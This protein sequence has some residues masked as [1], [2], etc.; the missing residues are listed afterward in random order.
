MIQSREM[1]GY[2]AFAADGVLYSDAGTALGSRFRSI[3]E[4]ARPGNL[5]SRLYF[6][7]AVPALQSLSRSVLSWYVLR[8]TRTA[9]AQRLDFLGEVRCRPAQYS[10]L[11]KGTWES[12]MRW[13]VE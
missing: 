10:E 12:F 5:L 6:D 8:L 3:G 7:G 1:I 11:G 2:Q 13:S 9:P 4:L